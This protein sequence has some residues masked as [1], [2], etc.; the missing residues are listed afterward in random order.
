MPLRYADARSVAQAIN[1]AFRRGRARPRRAGRRPSSATAAIA[2]ATRA[3]WSP[4]RAHR[5][6]GLGPRLRRAADQLHH[7]LRVPAEHPQDRADRRTSSTS[8]TS[9]S[10]PR[11]TS[12]RSARAT[13]NPSPQALNNLFAAEGEGRRGLRIVGDPVSNTLIVRA[14][15][16]DYAQV[17]ALAEALQQE[18]GEGGLLVRVITLKDASAVRIGTPSR[19]LPRQGRSGRTSRSRCR[20]THRQ[21]ARHRVHRVAVRGDPGHRRAARRALAPG[22]GQGIFIIEL[23]HISPDEVKSIIE[24]IGLHQPQREDSASRIVTEPIRVSVL[25]GRPAVIVSP[26]RPI[27]TRW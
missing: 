1:Q 20:W 15:D 22:S 18:A 14:E 19:R 26:T 3:T 11:R 2:T 9:P 21:H 16:E 6:R 25:E 23:E 5:G 4:R 12:F 10:S 24:T 13:P 27:A 17:L 8:R 7:R